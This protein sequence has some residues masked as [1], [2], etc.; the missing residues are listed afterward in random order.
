MCTAVFTIGYSDPDPIIAKRKLLHKC[1]YE[2]GGVYDGQRIGDAVHSIWGAQCESA[3]I[4]VGRARGDNEPESGDRPAG[5]NT[6][7]AA[8]A[9][10]QPVPLVCGAPVGPVGEL[11]SAAPFHRLR[12]DADP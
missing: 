8:A 1:L 5:G 3:L 10:L 11:P 12:L 9:R 4:S 6:S 7:T 2:Q